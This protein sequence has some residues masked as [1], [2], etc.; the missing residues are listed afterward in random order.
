MA[1]FLLVGTAAC[2]GS[3]D[4]GSSDG[5]KTTKASGSGDDTASKDDGGGS[6]LPDPCELVTLDKASEIL[7]G[8]SAPADDMDSDPSTGLR[9]CTWQTKASKDDPTLDG[10][11]HVL[12]LTV[13]SPMGG[14]SAQEFFDSAKEAST[15]SADVDGCDDAYWV[16]GQLS[17]IKGKVLLG[18]AAGLADDSEDAKASTTDLMAAACGAL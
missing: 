15:G 5:T 17:A 16:G 12:T 4:A 6:D 18:A 3:S 1:A 8:E 7:G 13:L 14:M 10:A 2:G 11:G 9:A